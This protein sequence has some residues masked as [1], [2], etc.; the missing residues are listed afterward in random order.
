M[1]RLNSQQIRQ[2]DTSGIGPGPGQVLQQVQDGTAPDPNAIAD[3]LGSMEDGAQVVRMLP[4]AYF[5]NRLKE[6]IDIM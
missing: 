1:Q 2:Y 3:I 5:I 6:H 4:Q